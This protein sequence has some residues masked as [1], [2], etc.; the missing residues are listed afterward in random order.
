MPIVSMDTITMSMPSKRMTRV[1]ISGHRAANCM[2]EKIM[3]AV[4]LI[5]VTALCQPVM[6]DT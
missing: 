4:M 1:M 5:T 6:A 3:A 2:K